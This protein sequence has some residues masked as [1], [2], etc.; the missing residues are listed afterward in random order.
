MLSFVTLFTSCATGESNNM[1][2][3]QSAD[4]DRIHQ[5]SINLTEKCKAAVSVDTNLPNQYCQGNCMGWEIGHLSDD[6]FFVTC[7]IDEVLLHFAKEVVPVTPPTSNC[8]TDYLPQST[9]RIDMFQVEFPSVCQSACQ[10]KE[11]CVWFSVLDVG[12]DKFRCILIDSGSIANPLAHAASGNNEI[13]NQVDGEIVDCGIGSIMCLQDTRD[14]LSSLDYAIM[15]VEAQFDTMKGVSGPKFCRGSSNNIGDSICTS[16]HDIFSQYFTSGYADDGVADRFE[17][18]ASRFHGVDHL[19]GAGS[20]FSESS[21]NS[22]FPHDTRIAVD[23][24]KFIDVRLNELSVERG[25]E[26]A[27]D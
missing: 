22:K 14:M 9:N 15:G 19:L 8:F 20:V 4:F 6:E 17:T 11:D 5:N 1:V 2:L 3:V 21:W 7:K 26:N 13:C 16:S 27:S 18:A 12:V 24:A 23:G 25:H 10:D